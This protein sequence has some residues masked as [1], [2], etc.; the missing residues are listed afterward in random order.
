[1]EELKMFGYSIKIV[2]KRDLQQCDIYKRIVPKINKLCKDLI[3]WVNTFRF[4]EDHDLQFIYLSIDTLSACSDIYVENKYSSPSGAMSLS[5]SCERLVRLMASLGKFVSNVKDAGELIAKINEDPDAEHI[6]S[7]EYISN[8]CK[9]IIT[10]SE[11]TLIEMFNVIKCIAEN[12]LATLNYETIRISE[13]VD[14]IDEYKRR[15]K[16]FKSNMVGTKY[17]CTIL[18][19]AD[20]IF[21]DQMKRNNMKR[22]NSK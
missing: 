20:N 21:M 22:K 15:E 10:D 19:P 16:R 4:D 2:K 14:I 1:M 8:E 3:E 18:T 5:R 17:Q 13:G 11:D 9:S 12:M 7:I 6:N